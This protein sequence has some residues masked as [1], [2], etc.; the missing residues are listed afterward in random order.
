MTC[1]RAHARGLLADRVS[2]GR[3]RRAEPVG[4][5]DF[6]RRPFRAVEDEI[7]RDLDQQ[8]V[9]VVRGIRQK[10]DRRAVDRRRQMLVRLR[11]VDLRVRGAVDDDVRLRSANGVANRGARR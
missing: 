1:F 8:R 9:D 3:T 10:L 11:V 2:S 6:V 7:G 5:V 4:V